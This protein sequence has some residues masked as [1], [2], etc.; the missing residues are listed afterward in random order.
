MT[1]LLLQLDLSD[2]VLILESQEERLSHEANQQLLPAIL[3][4]HETNSKLLLLEWE[5]IVR[6]AQSSNVRRK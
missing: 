5:S 4:A 6:P 3:A 1:L 2:D